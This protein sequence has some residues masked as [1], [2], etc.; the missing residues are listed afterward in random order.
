MEADTFS[1]GRRHQQFV[2]SRGQ[3][4]GY[5]F[6]PFRQR[7]CNLTVRTNPFKFGQRALINHAAAGR[8]NHVA[9]L[10]IFDRK[11]RRNLIALL[12]GKHVDDSAP[13][14]RFRGFGYLI[15]LDTVYLSVVC[16]KQEVVVRVADEQRGHE[17]FVLRLVCRH[18]HTAA[19]LRL[20]FGNGDTFYVALVRHADDHVF[21]LDEVGNVDFRHIVA[22]FRT[23]RIVVLV[24]HFGEFGFDDFANA[25][26]F[27]QNIA[28]IG[29]RNLQFF[30]FGAEFLH[31]QTGQP[32]QAH[33]QNGVC[34]LF[35][36]QEAFHQTRARVLRIL[37]RFDDCHD[38]VDIGLRNDQ[39]FHDVFT[40]QRLVQ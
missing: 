5:Q 14:A 2:F 13:F 9:F 7:D 11:E 1:F 40:F 22:Q 26:G 28:V 17:I 24:T 4:G 32:S 20:V 6:V 16:E 19:V 18:A 38:F 15:C 30:Q 3:V 27:F 23:A 29:N 33:I 37:A 21:F 35:T 36:Q 39:T 25:F 34:L 12:Q 8:H 10:V 31:F